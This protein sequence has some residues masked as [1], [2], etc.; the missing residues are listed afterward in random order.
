MNRRIGTASG[1]IG[2]SAWE[3]RFPCGRVVT[4]RPE[5]PTS[6]ALLC[7]SFCRHGGRSPRGVPFELMGPQFGLRHLFPQ[8][9]YF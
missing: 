3:G 8:G 1:R 9:N 7:P 4:P 5:R 6:S 2:L